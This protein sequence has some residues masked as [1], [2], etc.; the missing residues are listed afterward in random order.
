MAD[1]TYESL[2][3]EL[4]GRVVGYTFSRGQG[5]PLVFLWAVGTGLFLSVWSI[6]QMA[7]IW[8]LAAGLFG[9]LIV[10]DHLSNPKVLAQVSRS[11]LQARFP[12]E[13][14]SDAGHRDAIGKGIDVFQEVLAKLGDILKKRGLDEDLTQTVSDM[15]R[16]LALEYESAQQV[17]EME[18]IL[19]FIGADEAGSVR[20][21]RPR[22]SGTQD[23]AQDAAELHRQNVAAI[24]REATEADELVDVI[25]QRMETLMLQVFQMERQAI[26]LVT[27]AEAR[28]G[29]A[30]AIERLQ[31]LVDARRAAARQLI[32][33]VA[34]DL[35]VS[36]G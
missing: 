34:P 16:L 31:Q 18:R 12:A 4:R 21:R 13:R 15:D 3:R 33:L 23:V 24:Q 7:G 9:G 5:G 27:T 1:L 19:R 32:E 26:D 29:S 20:T 14:L 30:E 11:F 2:Q 17:E 36:A 25:G 6:P 22:A 35:R 10:R 28:Q 8:T